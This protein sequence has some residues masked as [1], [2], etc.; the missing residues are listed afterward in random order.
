MSKLTIAFLLLAI[1]L[2]AQ[3]VNHNHPQETIDGAV[4]PELIPDSTAWR[5]WML[6][7]TAKDPQH[8]ELAEQREEAFLAKAGFSEADRPQVKQA[9]ENFRTAYEKIL[10]DQGNTLKA[11]RDLLVTETQ[12]NLLALRPK[13][14]EFIQGEKVRMRV[15]RSEVQP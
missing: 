3:T 5:L 13:L 7:V 10:Q 8:P 6:S 11:R 12:V 2:V 1:P 14:K 4:H 15:P 9:L